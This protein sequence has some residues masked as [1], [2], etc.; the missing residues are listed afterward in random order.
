M[1]FDGLRGQC[2][3]HVRPRA[4]RRDPSS[5]PRPREL[6]V[7][8]LR[9]DHDPVERVYPEPR[10]RSSPT[11]SRTPRKE[12]HH[13]LEAGAAGVAQRARRRATPCPRSR[14]ARRAAAGRGPGSRYCITC[15]TMRCR[16]S[17]RSSSVFPSVVWLEIWKKL[18]TTSL[19]SPYSPRK[20]SPTCAIPCSTLLISWVQ[21]QPREVHQHRGAEPRAHVGR[22]AGQV[23]ELAVEGEGQPRAQ[24]VVEP[25]GGL[26]RVAQPEAAEERLQPQV[27]FLVHH[28]AHRRGRARAGARRRSAGARPRSRPARGSPGGARAGAGARRAEASGPRWRRGALQRLGASAAATV[29]RSTS[30]R[31]AGSARWP[32]RNPWRLRAS[33]MRV[34]STTSLLGPSEPGASRARPPGSPGRSGSGISESAEC[35]VLSA[36]DASSGHRALRLSA[37]SGSLRLATSPV[38]GEVEFPGA[39]ATRTG[40]AASAVARPVAGTTSL[41]PPPSPGTGEGLRSKAQGEGAAAAGA[42]PGLPFKPVPPA[43]GSGRGAPRRARSPPRRPRAAG[44]AAARS[45]APC[46]PPR[47]GRRKGRPCPRAACRRAACAAIPSARARTPPSSG[48]SPA[49]AGALEIDQREAAT[50]QVPTVVTVD[51][52][53]RATRRHRK[54]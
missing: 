52:D 41:R 28:H 53:S 35:Q 51:Q 20:V 32:K 21:H 31:S 43:C 18:P 7:R 40:S 34:E 29:R 49:E 46:G 6:Q 25:L 36:D 11:P 45:P 42:H 38:P 14:C 10:M 54:A 30:A 13:L 8:G 33:R 3:P 23:A 2:L 15:C 5:P 22:A 26:P 19:P 44:C 48:R 4:A 27:V 47:S 17:I 12:V 50:R 16:W 37:L 1:P 24:L 39:C 9:E